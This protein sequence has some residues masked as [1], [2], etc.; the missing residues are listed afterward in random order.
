MKKLISLVSLLLCSACVRAQNIEGQIIASQYGK[1]RVPGYASNTYSS[2]APDSC[3]VQGGASFFEAFTV[4]TPVEIVDSSPSSSEIV[5]PSST[6][7]NNVSCSVAIAPINDHQLPF[8]L[9]SATGGLQEALNNNLTSPEPN[10]VILDAAFYQLLPSGTNAATVIAS[11]KGGPTLGLVDITTV[12]TTWYQW[13]GTQYVKVNVAGTSGA[14]GTLVNDELANNATD[15]GAV[16]LYNFAATSTYSPASAVAAAEAHNGMVT[17]MPSVG[18]QAFLNTGNVRVE[19]ERVDIPAKARGVTEFG[20]QCDLISRAAAFSQGSTA[21]SIGSI[22]MDQSYV[23]R[24]IVAVGSVSGVPTVF[25]SA[26]ATVI[27][28]TD[29][30]VTTPFPF[31]QSPAHAVDIGHDDTA[32]IALGMVTV[33][34]GGTL[35]FPTGNCLTH[36]QTL[37]GQSPIG[38]GPNS[39]ITGFPGEDIF[40]APDPSLTAGANQGDVHIHDL[41]LAIDQR[42][43]ATKAWQLITDTS[44]VSKPAMYRPIATRSGVASDPLA[45]GWFQGSGPNLSGAFNGVASITSGSAVICVPTSEATPAVGQTVVF[46]YLPSVFTTTVSSTAGTCSAGSTPL[47]MAANLPATTA[48]AEWFAGTSP[49]NLAAAIT[50]STCPST[51]TLSN[52]INPVPGFESNVAPFGLIQID[53]E[54][55]SYFAKSNASNPNPANTLYNIQCGQNGTARANHSVG[56]TVVPLNPFQ[57]SYPW[58]VIPTLNSGDTTPAGNASY[59]PGWN[60]GNVAFAFPIA[61]GKTAGAFGAWGPNSRIENISAFYFPG[62]INGA[63]WG[64]V[65]HGGL[66]YFVSPPYGAKFTSISALYLFYGLTEGAPSIENGNWASG[67]PTAD[68]TTWDQVA[69]WA[70]NP[71]NMVTG[72]QNSFSNFNVYS[73][74]GTTTG[75]GL[76]ADTCFYF[77]QTASDQTGGTIGIIGNTEFHNLYCEP[78]GGSHAVQMPQWEWDT[79]GSQIYDQ[80]M[81]GGGEVYIGG[82]QQHWVSGNFNNAVST[83]TINWGRGNTAD[84]VTN[85]GSEPKGNVYGT[86]SFINFAPFIKFSGTTSQVFSSPTGPWGNLAAGNTRE[87]IRSQTN[88]TF[89]T[90]NL[91]AP[92][93]SSEGGFITPEEFNADFAFESQ[94]MSVGWT[95]DA[96]SPI[97]NAYTACNVGNNAGSIYCATGRFNLESLPVGPGQRLVGGKYTLYISMKDAVAATNTA[98]IS[99]FGSCGGFSQSYSIPIANTWPAGAA[100]VFTTQID[101]TSAA[102]PGC[103][104]GIRFWGATT[105]DQIQVGYM[106]FAPLAEQ[107]N[108]VTLNTTYLNL[109]PG[110]TGGSANGCSQSP[111]TGIDGGYTCPTKGWSSTLTANQGLTDTT[112]SIASTA[113]LSPSGCFFVDG[114]YECYTGITGSTLIGL[115][116]GAYVTAAATHNAGVGV[117]SVNL[118]LGSV[119]QT[120]SDVIAYGGS[121]APILAL[122]NPTPFNHGGSSVFSINSGNNE[123]WVDTAGA[124]HQSNVYANSWF[125]GSLLVGVLLPNHP[126]I[127]D[128]GYLLQSNAANTDYQ[129]LT[130]G[131]GHAGSLNVIQTPTLGASTI[132]LNVVS[133]TSTVSYVCSG[134]DFDGNLITGTTANAVNVASSWAFPSSIQVVCPYS[135]GVNTYQIYRTVGGVDQGLIASGPGPGFATYDFDEPSSG[136]LPPSTNGSNPHIS[137]AGTGNPTITMGTASITFSP[138]APSGSCV[139]GSLWTNSGGSPNTLYVCQS[140]AWVGK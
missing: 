16:D 68:G 25:E 109:P 44:T 50:S 135:A 39:F 62:D 58:P 71:V 11:V 42:I 90:G 77:T 96:T 49:Q 93:V 41:S 116:R 23:G 26:I 66:F 53:G 137:V 34:G 2:F 15:T 83:P 46:P 3:R 127:T 72:G 80:H 112:I 7:E 87:P 21:I 139:S 48:Q 28:G 5:T 4:G 27:D 110:A 98:K 84:Y 9:T 81:G 52:S 17:L 101:L 100:Q 94:A 121:E 136:G 99:I 45:P 129:P 113:G 65:N 38:L 47:T 92:Y 123:T 132:N 30:T 1:W 122:N 82:G 22:A 70:A 103:A 119:Q 88:E 67:Q 56:A 125:E 64:S 6:V 43:D 36:T 18:R 54:Q 76:G 59:F 126:S 79:V 12:P 40:A 104:L 124:F 78:E 57:P 107:L 75:S 61:S 102:G 91:T 20:A 117:V 74:E 128:T 118:V 37:T 106:D 95:Y 10:T 130:L 134:T 14:L 97:T 108:A 24:S 114:E 111:V 69:I 60:V 51:I 63:S 133:G 33:G 115:T 19:D 120:P 140:G 89:N 32:A 86:N 131:G 73:A 55:F 29:A 105:A 35:V 31:T 85:L 138:G 8:Y 13:N